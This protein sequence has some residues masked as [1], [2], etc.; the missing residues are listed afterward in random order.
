LLG[1]IAGERYSSVRQRSAKMQQIRIGS[2]E[3]C[4]SKSRHWKAFT[5]VELLVVIAVIAILAGLLLPALSK[6]K[7]RAQTIQCLNNLRQLQLAWYLYA[8]D[9][10]DRIAGNRHTEVGGKYPDAPSWVSGLMTYE[11]LAAAAPWFS[12]S[13]NTLLL[14]PGGYG[15]IGVYTKSPAIY[16][17]PA[18]K[19]WIQIG[20]QAH[21]RV[22]SVSMNC[23]M[24]GGGFGD[25]YWWYVFRKTTDI[26]TP[27]PSQA[28]VFVDE[29]EDSITIGHFSGAAGT[30]WP[31]TRWLQLP[32]SRHGAACTFSFADGHAEIKKWLDPRTIVPVKRLVGWFDG[33]SPQNRDVLWVTERASSKKPDAP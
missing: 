16:K 33:N 19:S 21:P 23:Y 30:V 11:T 20:G 1:K 31:D 7:A 3:R 27:G 10:K 26:V 8:D 6:A 32:A 14:V 22:R 17:C 5:L 24:N 12:D 9:H 28:F 2:L 29:H 15:G 18:D 13:T 4:D 25:D